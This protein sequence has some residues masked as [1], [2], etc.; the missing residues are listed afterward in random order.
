MTTTCPGAATCFF[1]KEEKGSHVLG[2]QCCF[3]ADWAQIFYN[4]PLFDACGVK[5]MTTIQS[6]QVLVFHIV[7]LQ[8][9]RSTMFSNANELPL[10]LSQNNKPVLRKSSK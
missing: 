1:P 5:V 7:F 10:I 3:L 6:A 8:C 9:S 4:Q 2:V